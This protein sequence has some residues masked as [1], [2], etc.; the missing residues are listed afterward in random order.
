MQ[1]YFFQLIHADIWDPCSISSINGYRYFLTIVD[2]FSRRTWLFL[3]KNK[4]ETRLALQFFCASVET[5]FNSKVCIIRT[6]NGSKFFME[7]FY[8]SKGILHQTSRVE[9]PQQNGFVERKYQHIL[10]VARSLIFQSHL[11][12]IFWSYAIIHS[13]FIINRLPT[14]LLKK[15]L[16]TKFSTTPSQITLLLR[17]LAVLLLPPP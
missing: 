11:P 9:T 5:Q 7:A 3:I 10:N 6:D 12:K 17:C 13:V 8:S 1:Y 2:D 15:S 14:P 16:L 4:S